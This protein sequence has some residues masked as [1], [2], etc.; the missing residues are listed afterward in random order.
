MRRKYKKY[1]EDDP[2]N[3]I[4][5]TIF[6][7]I[8]FY[9]VFLFFQFQTNRANFWRWSIYGI[10]FFLIIILLILAFRKM[11]FKIEENN[12]QSLLKQIRDANQEEGI[13]NFINNFGFT[14]RKNNSWSFR[15]HFIEWDR[16]NDLEK[17]LKEKGIKLKMENKQKDVFT[18]L[19]YYIEKKEE[20]TTRESIKRDPQKFASLSGHDFENLIYRLFSAMHYSVERIGKTGDQGGD[21]IANKDGE[22]TLIQ[23]KCYKDW[24]TGNAAVQQ[25]VAAKQHYNC[26]KAMVITTSYFTREAIELAG[27]TRTQLIS[28]ERLQEMLLKYLEESWK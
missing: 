16:I 13:I 15:N 22:R 6:V 14:G 17:I 18:L 3:K 9:F 28:K 8:I 4:V 20:K 12:K 7:I 10:I 27:T 11:K 2:V 21:L 1:Y 5:E 25:A 19:R 23:A 24:S 26:N